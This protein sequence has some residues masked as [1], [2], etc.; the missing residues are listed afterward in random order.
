MNGIFMEVVIYR[1]FRMRN[2]SNYS[3]LDISNQN[4]LCFIQALGF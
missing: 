4:A 1:D 2:S 3:S